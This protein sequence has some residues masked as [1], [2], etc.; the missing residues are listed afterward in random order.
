MESQGSSN[1]HV[2][3]QK[4]GDQITRNDGEEKVTGNE[5][6]LSVVDSS[7][8]LLTRTAE[9]IT[10]DSSRGSYIF[11]RPEWLMEDSEALH[12]RRK[13]L[14]A[15]QYE[16]RKKKRL[17]EN[18]EAAVGDNSLGKDYWPFS[19]VVSRHGCGHDVCEN[20]RAPGEL[21]VGGGEDNRPD[22]PPQSRP[23]GRFLDLHPEAAEVRA[24]MR[25]RKEK[26]PT[27]YSLNERF[28]R[29]LTKEDK[30]ESK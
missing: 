24:E 27:T 13:E 29:F 12:L 18:M 19:A 1:D 28:G 6:N 26:K 15:F 23:K 16:A 5:S 3:L 8:D 22:P 11:S 10:E 14:V 30:E 2:G 9:T 4:Q 20:A 21:L 7:S 17:C 25:A